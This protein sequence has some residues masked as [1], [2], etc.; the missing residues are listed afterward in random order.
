M[1]ASVL[2]VV[3]NLTPP[4]SVR[5]LLTGWYHGVRGAAVSGGAVRV[6]LC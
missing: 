6:E 1:T 5:T 4:G 2:R 3:T